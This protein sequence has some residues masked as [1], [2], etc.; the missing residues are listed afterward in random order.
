MLK[1]E[2]EYCATR[3]AHLNSFVSELKVMAA[4]HGTDESVL[5]EDLNEAQHNISYYEGELDRI[6]EELGGRGGGGYVG[7]PR[8][9]YDSILPRTPRQ[10]VGAA[11]LVSLGLLAGV[12]IGSQLASRKRGGSDD[13]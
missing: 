12:L 3:L 1:D 11:L 7:A 6:S 8:P 9:R 2:A 13:R 5:G 10:G 4:K